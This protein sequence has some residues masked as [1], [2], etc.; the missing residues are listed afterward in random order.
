VIT[1]PPPDWARRFLFAHFHDRLF[2]VVV[3]KRGASARIIVAPSREA[4][5]R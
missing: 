2:F 4:N 3:L 1:S 5:S